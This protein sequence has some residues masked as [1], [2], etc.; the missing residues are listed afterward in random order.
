MSVRCAPLNRGESSA[1]S[2]PRQVIER[3]SP[4]G[5]LSKTVL[6]RRRC[7]RSTPKNEVSCRRLTLCVT[8]GLQCDVQHFPSLETTPAA[9]AFKNLFRVPVNLP[10]GRSNRHR[11]GSCYGLIDHLPAVGKITV[12]PSCRQALFISM[13][14][15]SSVEIRIE[16]R[17]ADFDGATAFQVAAVKEA[18]PSAEPAAARAG[19]RAK[20]SARPLRVRTAPSS[21]PR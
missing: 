16:E 2:E 19:N 1:H 5:L 14:D 9:S 13:L 3:S 17:W 15:R 7:A 20:P 12:S 8:A 21:T 10:G 4:I 11:H 6:N 18:A